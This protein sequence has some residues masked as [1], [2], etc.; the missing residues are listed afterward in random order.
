MKYKFGLIGNKIFYSLSPK[1]HEQIMTING[2]GGTYEIMDVTTFPDRGVLSQ[3]DGFNITTPFKENALK[4]ADSLDFSARNTGAVNTLGINDSIIGYNTDYLATRF[5]LETK[6]NHFSTA[7][8]IGTGGAARAAIAV[9]M[10]L[11][12]DVISIKGRDQKKVDR[13]IEFFRIYDRSRTTLESRY[14]VVINAVSPDGFSFLHE[15][16]ANLTFTFYIDYVYHL[17]SPLSRKAK[18]YGI[19]GIS[20][21]EI[22]LLQAILSEEIWTDSNL[23][24]L[25]DL[26]AIRN[27]I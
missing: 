4:I 9:L 1:I 7:M 18:K 16:L 17:E 19:H 8:V 11:G 20:G 10:D 27:V 23:S 24:H 25:Y 14:D 22:L 2:F 26:E 13:L 3:F 15:T 5:L 21:I 6:S 12:F